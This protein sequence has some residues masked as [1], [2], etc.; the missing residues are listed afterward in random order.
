MGGGS[1]DVILGLV[2]RQGR[3]DRR[4]DSGLLARGLFG[5]REPGGGKVE[6]KRRVL[7]IPQSRR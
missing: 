7:G 6:S 4:V 5:E 3:A 1:F 2:V